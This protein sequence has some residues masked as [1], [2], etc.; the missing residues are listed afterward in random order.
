MSRRSTRRAAARRRLAPSRRI[1][2]LA[3]HH[4]VGRSL[5]RRKL[6]LEPL[7]DRHLLAITVTTLA[8]TVDFND[9][10]TSL[11]EAIFA[12]NTVPGADT[13]H[14]APALT[15]AG[16]ATILL[17]M[18]ELA[19][20]DSLTIDGPGADLL[21]IDAQQQSRILNIAATAGNTTIAGLSLTGGRI[22]N[23]RSHGGA[24]SSQT[25]GL[26]TVDGCAITGNKA[27]GDFVGGG[28]IFSVGHLFLSRSIVSG[29][30]TA[31]DFSGGGGIRSYGY[32][33]I[34]QSIVSGNVTKGNYSKGGGICAG[35]TTITRSTVSENAT[36]GSNADGGG[37][38]GGKVAVSN[39]VVSGNRTEGNLSSGGGIYGMYIQLTRSSVLENSTTG[40][41]ASGGGIIGLNLGGYPSP[42]GIII[43]ES[44]V[45]G[46]RTAKAIAS[47]GGIY[48]FVPVTISKS[49]I[50]ENSTAGERAHGGGIFA[51]GADITLSQ[52]V[53]SGN[54]TEGVNAHG[55]GVCSDGYY[56]TVTLSH[57]TITNNHARGPGARGGGFIATIQFTDDEIKIGGSIIVDNTAAGGGSD[58]WSLLRT[59][60][61]THSI[62]GGNA[63]TNL[64]EAPVG[65]PDANGNLIGGPVHG[66]IDPKLA[67]LADNGGFE[68]PDGSRI[69]THALLPGSPAINAGDLNAVAGQ[70]GVPDVDQRGEPF[71]RIVGGRIDIGA[72]E[73]QTPTDLN[74]LV[75]TLADESDGDYSRGD[76][77]LREAIELANQNRFAG[78]TDTIHFD[79]ALTAAGPATILLTRGELKITDSLTINGP[80]ADLLTIDASGNDPTPNVNDRKGSRVFLID[81]GRAASLTTNTISG[82]RLTGGD[83]YGSGGAI[84][85]AENVTIAKAMVTGNAINGDGQGIGGGIFIG[86]RQGSAAPRLVVQESE[87]SGNSTN[88]FGGGIA[89]RDAIVELRDCRIEN[90]SAA[91]GGGVSLHNSQASI[92]SVTLSKNKG[93]RGGG[94]HTQTGNVEVTTSVIEYNVAESGG[95]VYS[96]NTRLLVNSSRLFG[97]QATYGNGGAISG[98]EITIV[99]SQIYDNT[100]SANGGGLYGSAVIERSVFYINRAHDSGGAIFS[101]GLRLSNSTLSGNLAYGDG[102]A[103][104]TA[105]GDL[106]V[107]GSSMYDNTAYGGGGGISQYSS[108]G[109]AVIRSTTIARNNSRVGGGIHVRG[110][111]FTPCVVD[112]VTIIDNRA[113]VGGGAYLLGDNIDIHHTI[114][115]GNSARLGRDL[116]GLIGTDFELAYSLIGD[117]ANSGLAEAP[118]GAPDANGN[119]IGGAV[120]GP[121]DP[122]LQEVWYG[123]TPDRPDGLTVYVPDVSSPAVDAGNPNAVVGVDGIPEFDQRGPLFDRVVGARIDIG[124]VE[125]QLWGLLPGDFQRN[126]VIDARDYTVWRDSQGGVVSPGTGADGNGDGVVDEQDYAVWKSNFGATVREQG[127]GSVEQGAIANENVAAEL[128]PAETGAAGRELVAGRFGDSAP[129]PPAQMGVRVRAAEGA[130]LNFHLPRDRVLEA[131][132]SRRRFTIQDD[133][134]PPMST[135]ELEAS[136]VAV[137]D[138]VF[139][140]L[141][142][143]AKHT[144][145]EPG[146]AGRTGTVMPRRGNTMVR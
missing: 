22:G 119:L 59:M 72:F 89:A 19:I 67:P 17:T 128:P 122:L 66:L 130:R 16:P 92:I 33:T 100:A 68:L 70:G 86:R 88:R 45:R 65:S 14:F 109:K 93:R 8:D 106:E 32:V 108:Y 105:Y 117:N 74:L 120:Y 42:R 39:S 102:G 6:R 85:S 47:G 7:E 95:G 142:A 44:T 30:S 80:G 98:S 3:G 112:F 139:D 134:S 29:N 35:V 121:V 31:G 18:G 140:Q 40:P 138:T 87:I 84:S 99:G 23:M 21:T 73:Y 26:L 55:A 9:G 20:T 2:P 37:V 61:L 69:L 116:T 41:G 131:W 124:A 43:T 58:I 79:P 38:F 25:A 60:T 24:I 96:D 36:Y 91:S 62:I 141:D 143:F 114:I 48:S 135:S 83:I 127:A 57:S 1:R 125:V 11:R 82:L 63:G 49:T 53:V 90:N 54:S 103:I 115:A 101:R 71:G 113:S 146:A 76:L 51:L 4:S 50:S 104:C 111:E 46:N 110:S 133:L 144:R 5:N 136:G 52:S 145:A 12:A 132:L 81:D 118:I 78:V 77:S 64:A 28:G 137:I 123:P 56:G 15:A 13:I 10:A 107:V 94:L 27:V 97:N 126:R 75:D 129:Q 34:D